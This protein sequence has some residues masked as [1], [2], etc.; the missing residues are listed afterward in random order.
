MYIETLRAIGHVELMRVIAGPASSIYRD[1][2]PTRLLETGLTE[3][4]SEL[5]NHALGWMLSC[6]QV[7]PTCGLYCDLAETYL[8][9]RDFSTAQGYARH[10]VLEGDPSDER[11]FYMA[12]E[13]FFLQNSPASRTIAKK[14]AAAFTGKVT[15]EQ[16]RAVRAELAIS[17]I[18]ILADAQ[19]QEAA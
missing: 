11:A 6:E 14:Y 4:C 8:L 13:S 15:L 18:P 10:A 3:E 5:L 16:F 9:M 19:P 7:S 2:R 1:R 12:A 17:D